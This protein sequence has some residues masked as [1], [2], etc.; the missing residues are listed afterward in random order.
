MPITA[1]FHMHS[2]FSGDSD[3]PMEE[4]IQ[5]SINLGLTDICFTEHQDFDFI[6]KEDEP[7]DFFE[8]DTDKYRECLSALRDKYSNSVNIH[9]GIELGMQEHLG[10][11]N[12]NYIN[13][14]DFD[15][16]IASSHLAGRRDPY[17]PEYFSG[18]SEHEAYHA[19]FQGICDCLN[20]FSDFDIYGHLDYVLRYGPTKNSEFVFEEYKDIIDK[21]LMKL[22]ESGKGIEI[23]TSG[24]AYGMGGPH[25]A[26]DILREY[27][28]LGGDIITV[29][30]D[31]HKPQDIARYY[32]DAEEVLRSCGYK[33]YCIYKARK[34]Q[35]ISLDR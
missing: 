3:A 23:N 30:S 19:Y 25:P 16:V 17:L 1:D 31:A 6:Y 34:P 26:A 12:H 7:K 22:I 13:S 2:A 8:T 20:V 15:F 21:I 33:Y 5:K 14:Y 24:Y 18:R 29:G 35:H 27:R 10:A 11:K 4:M 32:R 28:L 9:F